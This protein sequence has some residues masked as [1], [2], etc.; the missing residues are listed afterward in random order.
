MAQGKIPQP[1]KTPT[2]KTPAQAREER[3]KAALKANMGRRKQQARGR[4][5]VNK[6]AQGATEES[7]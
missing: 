7:S 3:L 2:P 4:A 5:A 1:P 6:S